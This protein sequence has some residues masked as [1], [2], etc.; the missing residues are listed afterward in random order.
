VEVEVSQTWVLVRRGEFSV[1]VNLGLQQAV[2][3]VPEGSSVVLGWGEIGWP[4]EDGD[5]PA[6]RDGG[7]QVGP[8]AVAIVRTPTAGSGPADA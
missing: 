1:L 5:H 3:P 2:L 6:I 8:D 4:D 7:L